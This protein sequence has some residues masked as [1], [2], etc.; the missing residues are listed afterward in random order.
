MS[1]AYL[2]QITILHCERR[3]FLNP[4][5]Q[6]LHGFRQDRTTEQ[7][8]CTQQP[9]ECLGR[10]NR[11]ELHRR[12][13]FILRKDNMG[14]R[15]GSIC[16]F[17]LEIRG[18]QKTKISFT[19]GIGMERINLWIQGLQ[20]LYTSLFDSQTEGLGNSM[21][22][23]PKD[24]GKLITQKDASAV[25]SQSRRKGGL[26]TAAASRQQNTG[27]SLNE[28]RCMGNEQPVTAFMP[29]FSQFFGQGKHSLIQ[30]CLLYTSD[31]ADDRT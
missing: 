30:A 31:A 2:L 24:R 5:H 17:L 16:L 22:T 28:C 6:L 27:I 9:P 4:A 23:V 26:A 13:A 11:F 1:F 10:G 19:P 3:S 20:R 21:A 7:A 29:N 15:P 18:R 25:V 12:I 8:F 14:N